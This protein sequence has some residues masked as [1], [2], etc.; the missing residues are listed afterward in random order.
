[1]RA[2]SGAGTSPSSLI[3]L[4]LEV[5]SRAGLRLVTEACRRPGTTGHSHGDGLAL[6]LAQVSHC[7]GQ[8]WASPGA[9]LGTAPSPGAQAS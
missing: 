1:M 8:G 9:S 5:V 2:G 7:Q 3:L 4:C 6:S